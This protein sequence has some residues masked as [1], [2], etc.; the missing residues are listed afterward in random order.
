MHPHTAAYP[1]LTAKSGACKLGCTLGIIRNLQTL[2]AVQLRRG[3]LPHPHT[4]SFVA[5]V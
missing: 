3:C 1:Q 2:T 5:D 4:H